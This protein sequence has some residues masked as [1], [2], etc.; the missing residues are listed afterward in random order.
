MNEKLSMVH[1]HNELLL[2]Y[3]KNVCGADEMAQWLRVFAAC[4]EV[5]SSISATTLRLKTIYKKVGYYFLA[6]IALRHFF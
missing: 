4:R 5:L 3:L 2:S 1:L 6:Y